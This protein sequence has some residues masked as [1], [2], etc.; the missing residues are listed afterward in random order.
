MTQQLFAISAKPSRLDRVVSAIVLAGAAV[1]PVSV[2]V[3]GSA[4]FRLAPELAMVATAT[5]ALAV[6]L[7]GRLLGPP[8]RRLTPGR[9]RIASGLAIGA[10]G[11][12]TVA[13]V[14]S[15]NRAVSFD[16]LPFVFSV[17]TIALLSAL[18]FGGLTTES[19]AGIVAAP[20]FINLVV[21]ALQASRVWNPWTFE[22]PFS[23][24]YKNALLGNPND[25]GAYFVG[26]AIFMAAMAIGAARGRLYY[27]IAATA[28]TGAIVLTVTLTAIASLTLAL[29]ALVALRYRRGSFIALIVL[30][31]TFALAASLYR[32]LTE[33]I[34][35]I[36]ADG[37][38]S[39][40]DTLI[41]FRLPAMVSAWEMFK[42]DPVT[43]LGPGIYKLE[44]TAYRIAATEQ[45]GHWFAQTAPDITAHFAAAHNDHLQILAES[46]VAGYLLM[47]GAFLLVG[48]ISFA[49]GEPRSNQERVARLLAFP[50]CVGLGVTMIAGFP[51][52]LAAPAYTF[53][54]LGGAS[55]AWSSHDDVA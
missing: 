50:L 16:T 13:A 2:S 33:R 44:Y 37:D 35:R 28:F 53:V 46:G 1:V 22:G 55:I 47:L 36:A 24:I 52:Q 3:R 17:I 25:V 38:T 5:I 41:S 12:V 54:L 45:Y 42:D 40:L 31:T 26:P 14:F 8:R 20:A 15:N 4:V 39:R 51:L 23:R 27:G 43:G 48:S 19:V 10:V 21:L 29:A 34:V 32:P 6:F 18:L 49:T 11:W 9:A 7:V 30:G